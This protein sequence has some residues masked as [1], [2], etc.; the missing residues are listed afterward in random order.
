MTL[1][2][3]T[4]RIL[5]KQGVLMATK[6][7]KTEPSD[8]KLS[9]QQQAKRRK[10]ALLK[11]NMIEAMKQTLCNITKSS[12]LVGINRSTHQGWVNTD[13]EYA[14]AIDECYELQIDF[15]ESKLLNNVDADNVTAQIFFLKTKGK[16]RGYAEK[17]TV[18]H[19]A[20]DGVNLIQIDAS[21][22]RK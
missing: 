9:V 22:P 6:K 14:K 4:N 21:V 13:E 20:G 12:E 5:L 8:D 10:T 11:K 19:V 15:V 7:E 17:Q 16:R 3:D 2:T 1:K 18:E